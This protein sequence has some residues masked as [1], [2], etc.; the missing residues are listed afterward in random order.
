MSKR[1]ITVECKDGNVKISVEGVAG[2][3]C[4]D[5][6]KGL[7]LALGGKVISDTPTKEMQEVA[8]VRQGQVQRG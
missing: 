4:T 1:K 7:E 3:A 6:T 5:L 2:K 8:N